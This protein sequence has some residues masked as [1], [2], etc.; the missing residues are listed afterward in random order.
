MGG[1]VDCTIN[2]STQGMQIIGL[3]LFTVRIC[4]INTILKKMQYNIVHFDVFLQSDC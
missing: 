2:W 3:I 1:G 4:Q